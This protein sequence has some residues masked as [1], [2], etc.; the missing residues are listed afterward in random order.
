M[1]FRLLSTLTCLK[2]LMETASYGKFFL[3]HI[4]KRLLET[5]SFKNYAFSKGSTFETVF[6]TLHF[7]QHYQSFYLWSPVNMHQKVYVFKWKLC[8]SV[9]G[10]YAHI[11]T[12]YVFPMLSINCN[13]MY[14]L[15]V[16]IGSVDCLGP[17]WLATVT[18]LVLVL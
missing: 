12:M 8:I 2:T 1:H 3:Y 9:V 13:Q 7:H 18:A 17:L 16:L 15:Q 10:A 4:Q 11:H 14:L 6:K 5:E